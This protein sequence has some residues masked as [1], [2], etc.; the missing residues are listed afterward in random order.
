MCSMHPSSSLLVFL[1][2]NHV[3]TPPILLRRDFCENLYV[4][5][6]SS[7]CFRSGQLTAYWS[8]I[9]NGIGQV[10]TGRCWQPSSFIRYTMVRE[11]DH[12]SAFSNYG[13]ITV[14]RYRKLKPDVDGTEFWRSRLICRLVSGERRRLDGNISRILTFSSELI[15]NHIST[16]AVLVSGV[17]VF[18]VR[19]L[20]RPN[21]DYRWK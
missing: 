16:I 3:E 11:S 9:H 15:G 17:P 21:H 12:T 1:Y 7:R 14:D 8:T 19:S 13:S 18:W 5:A 20:T 10:L 2:L 4:L 6:F